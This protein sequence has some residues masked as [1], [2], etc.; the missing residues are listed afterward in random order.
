MPL[1]VCEDC[2]TLE[3][4]ALGLWWSRNLDLWPEASQGKA[5]C[6]ACMP[7]KYKDDSP[8]RRGGRWHGFFPRRQATAKDDVLNPEA[9]REG[10]W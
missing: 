1:F 9:L 5:L 6:S 4:T 7:T 3:N 10:S 8:T 2:G